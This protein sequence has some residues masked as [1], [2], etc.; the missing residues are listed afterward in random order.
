MRRFYLSDLINCGL[1]F[2]KGELVCNDANGHIRRISGRTKAI[3]RA[4]IGHRYIEIYNNRIIINLR[5]LTLGLNPNYQSY[6][7]PYLNETIC[8]FI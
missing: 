5:P 3:L 2:S 1:L 6:G 7:K 8:Y 4:F